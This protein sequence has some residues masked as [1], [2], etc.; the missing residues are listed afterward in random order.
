MLGFEATVPRKPEL[1]LP[2]A[3]ETELRAAFIEAGLLRPD[4]SPA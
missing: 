4:G 2:P 1:P 3:Q